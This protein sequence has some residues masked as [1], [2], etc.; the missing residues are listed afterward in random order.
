MRNTDTIVFWTPVLA[1]V[2]I[3]WLLT[4]RGKTTFGVLWGLVVIFL[5]WF[6]AEYWLYG[7]PCRAYPTCGASYYFRQLY[8]RRGYFVMTVVPIT[9]AALIVELLIKIPVA[10]NAWNFWSKVKLPSVHHCI[11][12][13]LVLVR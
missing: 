9:L 3:A 8:S 11:P 12:L 4:R 2:L 1:G 5:L 7:A 10:G 6:A 13:V